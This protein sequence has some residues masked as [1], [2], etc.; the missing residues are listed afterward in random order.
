MHPCRQGLKNDCP[1]AS[2]RAGLEAGECGLTC[3][4]LDGWLEPSKA[5]AEQTRKGASEQQER[6]GYWNRRY[7]CGFEIERLDA[8]VIIRANLEG[9]A[10]LTGTTT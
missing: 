3:S 9:I 4:G 7:R 8:E 5:Q 6:G 1:A 10:T 2:K